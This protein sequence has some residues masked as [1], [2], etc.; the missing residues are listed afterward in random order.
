MP[1]V[2]ASISHLH[3]DVNV[4]PFQAWEKENEAKG[5]KERHLRFNPKD[6]KQY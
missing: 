6:I 4:G 3:G 1:C 2:G 5:R